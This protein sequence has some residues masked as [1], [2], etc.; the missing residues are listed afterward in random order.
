MD[1]KKYTEV[2]TGCL[3]GA[4]YVS[5]DIQLGHLHKCVR[6]VIIVLLSIVKKS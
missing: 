3:C 1:Q 5:K 2:Y 4:R 6:C